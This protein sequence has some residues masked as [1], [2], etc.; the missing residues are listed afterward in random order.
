MNKRRHTDTGVDVVFDIFTEQEYTIT[1]C[2]CV[3]VCARPGV[4]RTHMNV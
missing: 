2:V 1:L 3:C 4:L